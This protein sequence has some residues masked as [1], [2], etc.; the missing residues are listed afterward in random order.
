MAPT[1]KWPGLKAFGNPHLPLTDPW[2]PY[3]RW[4]FALYLSPNLYANPEGTHALLRH[5]GSQG[6]A[7]LLDF[8]LETCH[9]VVSPPQEHTLSAN[10]FSSGEIYIVSTL[11][12]AFYINNI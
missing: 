2:Q 5:V 12:V 10:P 9:A 8:T 11:P 7:R 6:K 3:N 1:Q 4:C